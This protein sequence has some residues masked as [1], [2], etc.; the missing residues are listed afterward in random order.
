MKRNLVVRCLSLLLFMAAATA[1]LLANTSLARATATPEQTCQS[2]LA[3]AAATY[4]SCAERALAKFN[5]GG[6][7]VTVYATAAGKCVTK[8]A[9]TWPKLVAKR[10]GS[11]TCVD[12]RVVDNGTTVT[13]QLTALQWEKKTNLDGSTNFA[14]PHDADN[15][16]TWTAT[17]SGAVQV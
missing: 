10:A 15:T 5:L 6:S 8:Y 1:A 11:T 9:A 12:P 3:K 17:V 2:G 13:D 16:Y 14:D 4:T 7:S